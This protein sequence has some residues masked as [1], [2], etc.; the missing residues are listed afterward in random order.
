MV[1]IE[2]LLNEYKSDL[3]EPLMV[4]SK[5]LNVDK[6]Y[7]YTHIN[8]ELEPEIVDK[9]KTIMKK[10][11]ENYPL[12]YLLKEREFMGLNLFIDEGVL[13]PR[14]DTEILVEYLLD[15]ARGKNLD[16]LEIG[17]GSGAI[18]VALGYY[19]KN[20]RI[21]AVDISERALRV[22]AENI[23]RFELTNV[24]L[25]KS[26]VFSKVDKKFDI[27][28]SNP[29][30]IKTRVIEEL[31]SQVRDYEPRLALDGGEDG[32]YFY[33]KITREAKDYLLEGG[34]LI[35]EIGYDQGLDLEEIML[36]EG[37]ENIKI[38]KDLQGH[39]RVVMGNYKGR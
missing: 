4:L 32:L 8:R 22:A 7:I 11:G 21:L 26:D 6:S 23:S 16:I 31:D 3:L 10:R 15:Y 2:N 19:L 24:G 20:S 12:Q 39:N 5:L 27:I 30:Y 25:E 37:F 17:V 13:I 29:P 1:T 35:F 9:F 18:S 28:V 14:N 33:R 34:L 38:L 36:V